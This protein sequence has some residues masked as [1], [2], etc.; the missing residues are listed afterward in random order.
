MTHSM[1]RLSA[2]KN[3]IVSGQPSAWTAFLRCCSFHVCTN[4]RIYFPMAAFVQISAAMLFTHD[5]IQPVC[6]VLAACCELMLTARALG[7]VGHF[8]GTLPWAPLRKLIND[9]PQKF[10]KILFTCCRPHIVPVRSQRPQHGHRHGLLLQPRGARHRAQRPPARC[11]GGGPG[12]RHHPH[13]E[14]DHH[15]HVRHRR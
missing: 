2:A 13:A 4:R 1:R 3:V 10:S 5:R 11:I 14:P 7:S 12:G 6:A 15:G 8:I 9:L